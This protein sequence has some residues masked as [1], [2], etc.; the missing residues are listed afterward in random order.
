MSRLGLCYCG[1]GTIDKA[2][3]LGVHGDFSMDRG[4]VEALMEMLKE[5][6]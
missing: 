4:D 6:A 2:K 5:C 3:F 1:L